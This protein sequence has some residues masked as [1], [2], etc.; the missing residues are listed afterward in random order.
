MRRPPQYGLLVSP[1]ILGGKEL[2]CQT[3]LPF[4]PRGLPTP[5]QKSH[6]VVAETPLE[7]VFTS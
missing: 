2:T 5:V 3:Y 4:R 6:E 1:A 7:P